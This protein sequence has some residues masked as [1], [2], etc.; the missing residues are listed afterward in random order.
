MVKLM[1]CS[2]TGRHRVSRPIRAEIDSIQLPSAEC[3]LR[4]SRCHQPTIAPIGAMQLS[5][6]RCPCRPEP[7]G[8]TWERREPLVFLCEGISKMKR[9]PRKKYHVIS[10]I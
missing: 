10:A 2:P 4:R 7:M 6:F 8:L 9:T 5:Y 1:F 3:R